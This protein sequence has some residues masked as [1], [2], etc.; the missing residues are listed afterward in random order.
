AGGAAKSPNA[1]RLARRFQQAIERK[2]K[3]REAEGC[4]SA[5]DTLTG[6]TDPWELPQYN[7]FVLDATPEDIKRDLT[8]LCIR[9]CGEGEV[10][11]S[12]SE[13][14]LV[15]QSQARQNDGMDIDIEDAPHSIPKQPTRLPAN[16]VDFAQRERDE[17][18]DLTGATEIISVYP[19][20][21]PS[22]RSIR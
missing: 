19:R 2:R 6:G 5:A 8:H 13:I 21:G 14:I 15:E 1:L 22:S 18:R 17:M 4:C 9:L 12:L 10:P 3:Q 7:V 16:T 20:D 11:R